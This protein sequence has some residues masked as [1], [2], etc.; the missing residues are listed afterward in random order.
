M[1]FLQMKFS[2][3]L[4]SVKNC[5]GILVGIT[6]NMQTV[7]GQMAITLNLQIAFGKMAI[8]CMLIRMIHEHR[9]FD[10]LYNFFLQRLEVFI[11]QVFH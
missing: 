3:I 10:S 4:S 7:F 2:N 8:S 11:M 6:L 1:L 5:V 9:M